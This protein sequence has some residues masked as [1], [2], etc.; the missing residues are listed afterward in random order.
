[1]PVIADPE[2]VSAK[3]IQEFIDFT[4]KRVLEIGCGEGRITMAIAERSSHVTAIDPLAED[5]Q[6]AKQNTPDSLKRKINFITASIEDFD[7]PEGSAKFDIALF[8]WS[9]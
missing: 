4:D 1:M 5:I 7:L 2:G 6:T 8:S 3:V 9:L